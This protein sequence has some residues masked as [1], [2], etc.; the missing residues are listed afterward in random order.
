[1]LEITI[2]LLILSSSDQVLQKP[3]FFPV[4]QQ[5]KVTIP[6]TSAEGYY[7]QGIEFHQQGQ[8]N[9]AMEAYQEAINLNPKFDAAYINLGLLLISIGQLNEANSLFQKVLEL[10]DRPESPVS[11][12][13]LAYYNLAIIYSRQG[14]SAIALENIQ[15]ALAIAPD[16]PQ[17]KQLLNQLQDNL[18]N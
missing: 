7:R 13:A 18:S 6:S 14:K 5:S 2:S 9:E 4:A 16:F 17:A 15:K 11:T 1:M 3:R 12:H 8:V 10:G